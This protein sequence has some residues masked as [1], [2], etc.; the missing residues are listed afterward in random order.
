MP[1]ISIY[2]F[3]T[4]LCAVNLTFT[5]PHKLI[6]SYYLFMMSICLFI[7][8]RCVLNL[9]CIWGGGCFRDLVGSGGI[10]PKIMG[11]TDIKGRTVSMKAF[12]M[13]IRIFL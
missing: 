3:I 11:A 2:C 9:Q 5:I 1:Y 13:K 4:F 12:R 7:V 10:K 6:C 8:H